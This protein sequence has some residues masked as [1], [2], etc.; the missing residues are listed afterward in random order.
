MEREYQR[1]VQV[2]HASIKYDLRELKTMAEQYIAHFG[3][4]YSAIELLR[5]TSEVFSE[6]PEDEFWLPKY[7]TNALQEMVTGVKS[8]VNTRDNSTVGSPGSLAIMAAV[9]EVQYSRILELESTRGAYHPRPGVHMHGFG[10]DYY[11]NSRHFMHPMYPMPVRPTS[12]GSAVDSTSPG[13][14]RYHM[15]AT[16]SSEACPASPGSRRHPRAA[17]YSSEE[18][19]DGVREIPVTPDESSEHSVLTKDYISTKI[20]EDG[21][22]MKESTS[23]PDG[24]VMEEPVEM[25][26]YEESIVEAVEASVYE[27]SIAENSVTEEHFTEEPAD[28]WCAEVPAWE[29]PVPDEPVAEELTEEAPIEE[30]PIEEALTEEVPAEEEPVKEPSLEGTVAESIVAE[31]DQTQPLLLNS[32]WYDGWKDLSKSQRRERTKIL[33]HEGLPI[34]S[35]NGVISISLS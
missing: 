30:A 32:Q 5:L 16:P 4:E 29:E 9:I 18:S 14:R 34:P 17:S 8:K 25:V 35:R 3:K 20:T 31:A 15:P 12:P 27:E 7:V 11:P 28:E 33:K 26:S 23:R 24:T 21:S 2:Y 10:T 13:V 19:S 1:C 22:P 6:F